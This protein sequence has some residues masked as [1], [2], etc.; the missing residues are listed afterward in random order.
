MIVV[1]T[2]EIEQEMKTIKNGKGET[3]EMMTAIGNIY[4][5]RIIIMGY[6]GTNICIALK[7]LIMY[8][9]HIL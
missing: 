7:I 1:A 5:L 8:S 3:L 2:E 6:V 9:L 4:V